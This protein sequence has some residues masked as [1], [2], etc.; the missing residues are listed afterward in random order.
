MSSYA[1][2]PSFAQ[3]PKEYIILAGKIQHVDPLP[4]GEKTIVLT[5]PFGS[6]QPKKLIPLTDDGSFVD[7]LSTGSGEYIIWDGKNPVPLY[8]NQSKRYT[9]SYDADTFR[10]GT[11]ELGGDDA[12]INQYF[13]AKQQQRVFIDRLNTKRSEAEFRQLI[14]G[15]RQQAMARLQTAQL[16]HELRSAQAKAIQ[17]EYLYELHHFLYLKKEANSAFTPS[18][19]SEKELTIDY[20]NETDYRQDGYYRNLV[21]NYYMVQLNRLENEKKKANPSYSPLQNRL[22]LLSLIVPNESI[23]NGLITERAMY[24]LKEVKDVEAYYQDFQIYYTG[25]DEVFKADM[26]DAYLRLSKLKVGKP[27]PEFVNYRNYQGGTTSLKAFRGKYVYIDLWASWCGNCWGEMPFLKKL[28]QTYQGK[29]IVFVSISIDKD[30]HK[31]AATIKQKKMDGIQLLA[32]PADPSFTREY[33]VNGIPRY[34]LL[35]PNGAIVAYSA[36]RPSETGELAALLAK[37]GL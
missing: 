25:A 23:K 12:P 37:V 26:A 13:I 7:T 4:T 14:G 1:V 17:Y 11:V 5:P 28:E 35:D 22:K 15:I 34:I 27:S 20:L 31:W 29:N 16:P 36:P 19:E 30:V 10:K 21:H 2:C 18:I 8:L 33:A 32:N 9:I 24:E 3:A 6:N